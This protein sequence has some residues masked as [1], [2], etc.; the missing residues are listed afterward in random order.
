M[1]KIEVNTDFAV[2]TVI[3]KDDSNEEFLIRHVLHQFLKKYTHQFGQVATEAVM[4]ELRGYHSK[5]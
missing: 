2:I 5:G 4:A 3:G 1:T